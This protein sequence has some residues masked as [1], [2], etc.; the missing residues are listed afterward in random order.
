MTSGR[1]KG[2]GTVGREVRLLEGRKEVVHT[3][4]RKESGT[5]GIINVWVIFYVCSQTGFATALS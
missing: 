3:V 2:G 4:G 5:G 1:E